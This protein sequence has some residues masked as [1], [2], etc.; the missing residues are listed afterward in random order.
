MVQVKFYNDKKKDKKKKKDS[1]ENLE[2]LATM[3]D[4]MEKEPPNK[5]PI[6]VD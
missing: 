2:K 1:K 4:G 5:D 3:A 6:N